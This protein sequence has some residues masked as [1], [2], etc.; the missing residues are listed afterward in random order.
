LLVEGFK[1]ELNL[2]EHSDNIGRRGAHR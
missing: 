1:L 2:I